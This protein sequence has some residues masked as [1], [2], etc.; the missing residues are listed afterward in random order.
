MGQSPYC[1]LDD[2]PTPAPV[3]DTPVRV[4][5]E[6]IL[7]HQRPDRF[8]LAQGRVISGAGTGRAPRATGQGM[9][10]EDRFPFQASQE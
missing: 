5:R 7:L 1:L 9:P 6:M 4:D 2:L 10:R 8:E 3:G